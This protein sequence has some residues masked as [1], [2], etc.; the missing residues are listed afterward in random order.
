[1]FHAN[2][3]VGIRSNFLRLVA[4][5]RAPLQALQWAQL[6]RH[7]EQAGAAAATANRTQWLPAKTAYV[8]EDL[9]RRYAVHTSTLVIRADH[10]HSYPR[11]PDNVCWETMLL[12]YLMARG[13]CGYLD[14]TV[15]YYRRHHRGL[16]HNADRLRRLEMSW[17]CIDALASYFFGRFGW[18]L[19]DRELWIYGMDLALPGRDAWRHWRQNCS[20]LPR[21]C[22]R[23]LWQA[24]LQTCRLVIRIAAQPAWIFCNFARQKMALRR[25]LGG[26]SPRLKE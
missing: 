17:E 3:N 25:R 24:P 6:Q 1:M 19:V 2:A 14:R 7:P 22:V 11:F 12:G 10:L 8:L 13:N 4:H 16:W 5:A 18:E 26:V 23:T 9:L 21:L 20:L 15:S